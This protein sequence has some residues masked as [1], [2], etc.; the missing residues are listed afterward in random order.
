MKSNYLTRILG[1]SKYALTVGVLLFSVSAS[2]QSPDTTEE[3]TSV[4]PSAITGRV[5]A[6]S[7]QPIANATVRVLRL[8]SSNPPRP[9]PAGSDGSFK[10]SGLEPGVFLVTASAPSFVPAPADTDT[11]TT[12]LYRIGDVVTLSMVKGGVINGTVTGSDGQPVVAVRVRALMIRDSNGNAVRRPLTSERLTDDRGIYR[13]YGLA[14]GTYV[15]SAGGTNASGI[16]AGFGG[17]GGGPFFGGSPAAIYDR[18]APTFAPSSTRDT[19]TELNV[20]AGQELNDVNIRYRAEPGHAISGIVKTSIPAGNGFA[21]PSVT[22]ARAN[23]E[24]EVLTS[25]GAR[26]SAFEFY[27]IADGEYILSAQS[28]SGPGDAEIS[29]PQ[30]VIVN[31]ANVSGVVLATSPLGRISGRVIL[32]PSADPVCKDKRQPRLEEILVSTKRRD[33]PESNGLLPP[34]SSSTASPGKNGEFFLNKLVDGQYPLDVRFSGKY[35]YLRAVTGPPAPGKKTVRVGLQQPG[36]STDLVRAGVTLKPGAHFTGVSVVLTAGAASL[37][38]LAN[39]AE[40]EKLPH[41][42]YLVP[43]EKDQADNLLRYFGVRVSGDGQFSFSNLPP[44]SYWVVGR[45]L[46]ESETPAILRLTEGSQ[47][48]SLLRREGEAIKK[49]IEL[50][51][52]QNITDYNIGPTTA[53]PAPSAASTP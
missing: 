9:V 29:R 28:S 47:L 8:N 52:C 12:A 31:G 38:G 51:A 25:G 27:G 45:T 33:K 2:A 4:A 20:S 21:R 5:I 41:A 24:G 14:P 10:I 13:L 7:G 35:W 40:D 34:F 18:D 23:H 16:G 11:E 6:Q 3:T 37:R 46:V 17:R 42:L 19:A 26:G 30:K 48:R 15:V 22:L 36:Q 32:E 50:K 43:A 39:F 1:T 53:A 49:Q 44:G